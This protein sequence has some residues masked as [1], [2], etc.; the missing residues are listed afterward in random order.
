[1]SFEAYRN[2][3]Y[4][5]LIF[6]VRNYQKEIAF[7]EKNIATF[8]KIKVKDILDIAC[9]TGNH[10]IELAKLGYDVWGFDISKE[11]IDY[12]KS[13]IVN[14][15]TNVNLFVADMS[16]FDVPVKVDLCINMFNSFSCML[17]N[18]QFYSHLE[19]VSKALKSGGLYIVELSHP[20]QCW[21][22]QS[23]K[24]KQKCN[25]DSWS[26]SRDNISIKAEVWH[27][28]FDAET[29]IEKSGELILD[30][31]EG[32]KKFK[33]VHKE[34]S[35]IIFPQEFKMLIECSKNFEFLKWYGDFDF[36]KLD[37]NSYKAIAVLRRK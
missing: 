33:I 6:S 16:S 4:Y 18:N 29:Q 15:F 3:K 23:I 34:P 20:Y 17:E 26:V 1:M 7:I 2:P 22:S 13:K 35:R 28:P 11:M 24:E 25:L 30:I 27:D 21:I 9:G 36:K 32:D 19:S 37:R 5:D 10:I 31:E 14:K 8:S 12:I